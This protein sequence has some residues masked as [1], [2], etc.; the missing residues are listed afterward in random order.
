MIGITHQRPRSLRASII[1]LCLVLVSIP[2]GGLAQRQRAATSRQTAASASLTPKLIVVII[3][4][5][6]RYDYLERFGDLFGARGFRRLVNDGALFTNA[7][8]DYV[9]TVTAAGHAAIFTGSVPA[10]NGIVGN[11]LVDRET[12]K[13]LPIVSDESY[14]T[15]SNSGPSSRGGAGSPRVLQGTTIGDQ[16]RLANNFQSKVIAIS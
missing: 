13:S 6:F 8:Y 3:V 15:V 10:R 9:P 1:V 11:Y 12:G 7:N 16:I 4:D 2:A 14:H 5:Q